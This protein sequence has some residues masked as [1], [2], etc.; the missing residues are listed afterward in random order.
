MKKQ[1]E[2]TSVF[3][4]FLHIAIANSLIMRMKFNA[5]DGFKDIFLD[6]FST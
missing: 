1:P 4:L 5:I 2:F 3:R 6:F